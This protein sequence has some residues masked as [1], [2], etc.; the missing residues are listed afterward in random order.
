MR[1]V[2]LIH[3]WH[4][5]PDDGWKAWLKEDLKRRKIE[6]IA[7]HMPGGEDPLLEKWIK[8][9]TESVPNPDEETYFVGHSLGC[10]A[11]LKYLEQ[12]GKGIKVGGCVLVAG[13]CTPIGNVRIK[14]FTEKPLEAYKVKEHTQRFKIIGSKDDKKVPFAAVLEMQNK[15]GGQLIM[16]NGKGHFGESDGVKELPSLLR[17]LNELMQGR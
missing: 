14:N 5:D 1:K 12:L 11:I 3:G 7:P 17:A 2:V 15:L 10:I 8:K 4:G 6:V 9:I 13:F 16:D